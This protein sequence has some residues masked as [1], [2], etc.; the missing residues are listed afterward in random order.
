MKVRLPH[1]LTREEVRRRLEARNSE[2]VDYFPAGMAS[3]ETRWNGDDRMN[4]TVAIAG[5]RINGAVDIADDHVVIEVDLPLMLSFLEG[6]IERSVR[7]EGTR[8]LQ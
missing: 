5:Q 2:I 3:M 8:L 4:F 6:T 7:K 1:S